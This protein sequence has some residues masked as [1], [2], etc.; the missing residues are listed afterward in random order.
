MFLGSGMINC[1]AGRLATRRHPDAVV[2]DQL[3]ETLALA[4]RYP[5]AKRFDLRQRLLDHIETIARSMEYDLPRKLEPRDPATAAWL[6]RSYEEKAVALR[7]LKRWVCL[8][9]DDT[10]AHLCPRIAT[11][12]ISGASDDWDALERLPVE[13]LRQR[14]WT[15][16]ARWLR[17][18]AIA[19]LPLGVW[20]LLQQSGWALEGTSPQYIKLV[21]SA[22][23]LLTI[24][25]VTLASL[26]SGLLTEQRRDDGTSH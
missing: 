10:P 7:S 25:A 18:L 6:V 19:L 4:E 24:L 20:A 8:P 2:V 23:A 17:T 13:S 16:V 5:W 26:P 1:W 15:R 3:I 21:V 14:W 9:R 22:W 11:A 12:L